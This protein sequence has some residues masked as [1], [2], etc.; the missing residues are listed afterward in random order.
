MDTTKFPSGRKIFYFF[1]S[2]PY[3]Q[4]VVKRIIRDE[5]EIYTLSDYERGLPLIFHYNGALLF[6][7]IDELKDYGHIRAV[8]HDFCRQSANRSIELI[9]L[10]RDGDRA[11]ELRAFMKEMSN[12]RI[13]LL[14]ED[15][16]KSAEE[17]LDLLSGFEARGQR[18]YVRFGSS[19]DE[20]ALIEFVHKSKEVS[21]GVHDIS[22]VGLSFSL[23]DGPGLSIRSH[24]N[25]FDIE[26]SERIEGL[27]GTVTIKRKLPDGSVLYVLMFEKG[28]SKELRE[29]LHTIIHGS[30]QRQFN[31][32]LDSVAVP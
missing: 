19:K 4:Q 32:R 2:G 20:V 10:T 18:R 27:S 14:E 26:I 21:A 25:N 28:I 17:L 7:H 12:C 5:Y 11:E 16:E 24:I 29:K 9:I 1:P 15:P 13:I 23:T 31:R 3:H 22:S 6:F 30:L 8:L